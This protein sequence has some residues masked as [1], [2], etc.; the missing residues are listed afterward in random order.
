[1][2]CGHDSAAHECAALSMRIK[3]IPVEH[4]TGVLFVELLL[5]VPNSSTKVQTVDYNI[6]VHARI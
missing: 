1:M 5:I 3:L 6:I 4:V 2:F